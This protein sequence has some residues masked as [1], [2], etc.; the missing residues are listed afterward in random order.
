MLGDST[1]TSS[2][3]KKAL[4]PGRNYNSRYSSRS[5]NDR[6]RDRSRS[7]A[8]SR[9]ERDDESDDGASRYS[10]KKKKD[11]KW[12]RKPGYAKKGKAKKDDKK[13]KDK[14]ISI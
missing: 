5:R 9:R 14:G 12:Q 11:G 10:S 4:R 7:P 3:L 2:V 1:R 8:R 13:K 6:D